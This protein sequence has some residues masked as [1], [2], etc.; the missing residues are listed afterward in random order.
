MF[1]HQT[2]P[3]IISA[4]IHNPMTVT[5]VAAIKYYSSDSNHFVVYEMVPTTM[6]D[7]R[8]IPQVKRV[9]H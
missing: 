5:S 7:P 3:T 4:V 9:R 1:P 2:V 6:C 8:Y